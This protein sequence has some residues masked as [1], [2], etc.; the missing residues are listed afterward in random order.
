MILCP[1]SSFF[2]KKVSTTSQ[3]LI[4]DI[5]YAVGLVAAT[6]HGPILQ[7]FNKVVFLVLI[8]IMGGF[9]T[10][11]GSYLP[12][13][14]VIDIMEKEKDSKRRSGSYTAIFIT[15]QKFVMSIIHFVNGQILENLA[16]F[17]LD[18]EN[19]YSKKQ[20][21]S[22]KMV[23]IAL[24]AIGPSVVLFINFVLVCVYKYKYPKESKT[25]EETKKYY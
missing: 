3:Y 6:F 19:K 15:F 4:F 20:S 24:T 5:V 23:I 12:Y 17:A 14:L 7:H 1:M 25:G 2:V 22:T 13:A 9:G 18:D 21:E 8:S 10:T 11:A 16:N